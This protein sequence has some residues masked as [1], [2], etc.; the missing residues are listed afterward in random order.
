MTQLNHLGRIGKYVSRD[1]LQ[2]ILG[3]SRTDLSLRCGVKVICDLRA[4]H[5]VEGNTSGYSAAIDISS[6]L[7]VGVAAES[8]CGLHLSI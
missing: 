6:N 7:N 1:D 2:I 4:V 3:T 5:T 8:N